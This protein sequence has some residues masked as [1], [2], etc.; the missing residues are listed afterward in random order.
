[1][2]SDLPLIII[3]Q[4]KWIEATRL[5]AT[6]ADQRGIYWMAYCLCLDVSERIHTLK[7]MMD[8]LLHDNHNRMD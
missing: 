1:M 8:N 3:D 2:Y 5:N 4:T 7:Q 6:L